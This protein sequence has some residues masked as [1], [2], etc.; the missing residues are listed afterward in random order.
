MQ[1]H[2]ANVGKFN[3]SMIARGQIKAAQPVDL[4]GIVL[5]VCR[6]AFQEER[7]DLNS[8]IIGAYYLVGAENLSDALLLAKS[9]PRF[10]DVVWTMEIHPILDAKNVSAWDDAVEESS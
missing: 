6:G 2:V 7:L 3:E 5:S 4:D 1:R 8:E 10:E 9:D